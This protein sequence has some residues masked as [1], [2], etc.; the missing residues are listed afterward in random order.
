MILTQT[1]SFKGSV[2]YIAIIDDALDEGKLKHKN[3]SEVINEAIKEYLAKRGFQT[4]PFKVYDM[5]DIVEYKNSGKCKMIT[6]NS[7]HGEKKCMQRL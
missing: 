1:I 5:S 3:R 4:E 6:S 2:L 7:A